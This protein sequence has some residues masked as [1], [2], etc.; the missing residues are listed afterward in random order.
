MVQHLAR[1]L[2]QRL[3]RWA[4]ALRLRGFLLSHGLAGA[5]DFVAV[6]YRIYL[7]HSKIIHFRDGYPVYSLTTPALFSPPAAHFIARTLYRGIQNRNLPNLLSLAVTDGCNA[8]CGH[9]SFYEAVDDPGRSLLSLPE[10][11][12][13]IRDA[14]QLGVSILN[15]VGGE[16]LLR[17]D[18]AEIIASVDKSLST[19]V[20]FTNGWIWPS[21]RR[22]CVAPAST[23]FM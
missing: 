18:L 1:G 11:R 7:N 3:G 14:Q 6:L 23:A 15:L 17:P 8:R 4:Q 16:P 22:R 9:C 21:G 19:V 10:L 12:Q 5:S 13:L 20:L 2:T